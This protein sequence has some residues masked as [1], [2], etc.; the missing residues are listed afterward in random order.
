[1]AAG[2]AWM[3]EP[4]DPLNKSSNLDAEMV[5]EVISEPTELAGKGGAC[6]LSRMASITAKGAVVL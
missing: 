1:M 2:Q 6:S 4:E 3:V 5:L